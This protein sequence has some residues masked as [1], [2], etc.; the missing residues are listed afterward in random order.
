MKLYL[1][2]Y[3][4][5]REPQRLRELV[6]P[7]ARAAIIMNATDM[8]GD[9][10]RP[11]YR[12]KY[13]AALGELGFD[14]FEL[15]LREF[16]RAPNRLSAV[17]KDVG[18]L[19]VVGG[20]TFVLRRA[21]RLSGLDAWLPSQLREN[22]IVYGGFSAGACVA[23][24]SLRGIHLADDPAT[25]PSGYP[26]FDTIWDGLGLIDFHIVPHYRSPHP[27]SPLMEAVVAYHEAHAQPYRTLADGGVIIVDGANLEV[28][29]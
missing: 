15:D 26:P 9:D 23:Q 14:A 20:N 7:G 18:L 11:E 29:G 28:V 8:F 4:L 1:S 16:F 10:L 2:S 19:W 13:I 3:Q 12:A 6:G 17:L 5:G 24:S 25:L 27:E 21:M 22:R